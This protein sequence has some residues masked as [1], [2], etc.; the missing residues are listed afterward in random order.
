GV[1][2][3]RTPLAVHAVRVRRRGR[4]GGADPGRAPRRRHGTRA[5][6]EPRAAP[7][8]PR[9]PSCVRAAHRDPRAREHVVQHARRADRVHAA[10]CGRVLLHVAARRARDRLV[11]AREGT[12]MTPRISVV[13]PTYRR[14]AML[15]RCLTALAGQDLPAGEFEIVVVHD[16]PSDVTARLVRQWARRLAERGGPRLIFLSPP[17]GGPAAARNA[18]WRAASAGMVAFTDDDAVPDRG[19]LV[20]TLAAM[21]PDVDAAWGPVVVPLPKA[22]TDYEVDAARLALSQFV[23]ANCFCRKRLLERL[24]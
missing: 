18:G 17:H 21:T 23:T 14:P 19:W 8:V 1:V 9:A 2:R 4:Q 5:D 22:P 13:V 16:G 11:A 12:A 10:G 20:A 15:H 6:G 24:G 3:R 7:A